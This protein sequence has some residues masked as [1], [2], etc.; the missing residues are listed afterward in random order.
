ML[1]AFVNYAMVLAKRLNFFLFQLPKAEKD[2]STL[3][4]CGGVE[5]LKLR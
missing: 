4:N 2:K 5:F 1:R 3:V